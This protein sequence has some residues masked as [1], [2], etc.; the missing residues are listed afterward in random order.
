MAPLDQDGVKQRPR[1]NTTTF[2]SFWRRPR[3]ETLVFPSTPLSVDAL[4]D[5]LTP[6]A[7]PSL[8]HAR[9]LAAAL[10]SHS[11][12]P[13]PALLTPVVASLCGPDSPSSLQ[14]AGYEIIAAFWDSYH[15]AAVSTSDK[16]TFFSLVLH[17]AWSPDVGEARLKALI[18][19]TKG[20]KDVLGI[21]VLLINALKS[22][23]HAVF[24][25]YIVSPPSDR[26]D[27]ER[28]LDLLTSYMSSVLGDPATAARVSEGDLATVLQFYAL[29]ASRALDLPSSASSTPDT[30]SL[31]D[32]Q[33]PPPLTFSAGHRRHP[34]SLSLRSPP[35][36]VPLPAA[37][38]PADFIVTIYLDH[39][40]SQLKCLTPRTLAL[41]L[42][43]LFRAQAFFASPLPRLAITG[44]R[45]QAPVGLE[46]RIQKILHSLLTGPYGTS[47]MM[48][49]KRQLS[50][51]HPET[52][53]KRPSSHLA[54]DLDP[55]SSVACA[56]SLGAHRTLRNAIRQAL[57]S[58]MAR[59][60]IS[61]LTSTSYSPSGAP[62]QIDLERDLMERAWSKDDLSGWDLLKLGRMLSKSVHAWAKHDQ[63]EMDVPERDKILDE[64]AGTLKDIF[65]EL[66]ER[67]D[68]I[69]WDEE[70]ATIAGETLQ[71]LASFVRPLKSVSLSSLLSSSPSL[72]ETPMTPRSSFR[73]LSLPRLPLRF[74]AP[75]P[76]SSPGTTR[77]T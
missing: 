72:S 68:R 37:R 12:L 73:S 54:S 7:V 74:C 76:R 20:G 66:D 62:G 42:P 13:S 23:I 61:R 71:H 25:V 70:E 45:S 24:D 49:L 14:C 8:V 30:T 53:P 26:P 57:C 9:A 5:A 27:R 56:M 16:L 40:L 36:L 41:I 48:I 22:W 60:Y 21:E 51:P 19:L 28:I 77:R 58:K 46:E 2:P 18:A 63:P 1:S 50:P 3:Q 10:P 17:S 44:G 6:P 43:L 47:C 34:S 31:V 38:H 65:Q 33:Q 4:L 35:V 29:L 64:A 69:E 32:Q 52:A 59:A 39:L 11:P 75:S 15:D 67:E 55:S